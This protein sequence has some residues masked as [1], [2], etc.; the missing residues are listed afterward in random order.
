M[1]E[2]PVARRDNIFA[3]GVFFLIPP[4]T[5]VSSYPDAFL[6]RMNFAPPFEA[7]SIVAI[8]VG[9][10]ALRHGAQEGHVKESA[11]AAVHTI[12]QEHLVDML[13]AHEGRL[14]YR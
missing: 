13:K 7:S 9:F 14:K 12:K 1:L 11:F 2:F 3:D 6:V 8:S 4:Q 10:G 5:S